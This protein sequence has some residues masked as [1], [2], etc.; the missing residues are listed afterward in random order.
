MG[1]KDYSLSTLWGIH[2]G[3]TGDADSIFLKKNQVALGWEQM[4]DLGALSPSRDA[5]K[6]RL[7]GVEPDRKPGYYP[8]AAGQLFCFVHEMKN[9]DLIVYPSKLDKHV[10]IGEIIGAYQFIQKATES[11]P[12]RRMV[13]WLKDFPRIKFSQGALYEIGSAISFFQ[14]KNYADEFIAALSGQPTVTNGG[15][16]ETA[17]YVAEDIEQ[18]TRDYILKT[19][20]Q[21]LKGHALADFVAHL[22]GTMGY[23]TRVAP[24][25]P[26][27]GVDIIAHQD[28]L[29]F[30]PPIIKVQV[31][32]TEGSV[33]DPVVSQLIGKLETGEYGMLVTLG[34]FTSQAL[35]TARNKS[36]LRLIN[37]DELVNLVL[38]HYEEFDSKYKG[39]MPLKRVYVPEP[40][41]EAVE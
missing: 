30:V 37:G 23:R 26:D 35:N 10:H 41:E 12:H 22:L 4:G 21:E 8:A 28:E 34:T 40:L 6:E 1:G 19:L 36:N 2:G 11:Y 25:G 7:L 14:V 5:F 38:Q 18:N 32:S 31:K 13:K 16:D 27:G 39:M 3:R 15:K 24:P 29:G 17:P 33:G 9:G 20:A